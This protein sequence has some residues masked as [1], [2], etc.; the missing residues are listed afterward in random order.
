MRKERSRRIDHTHKRLAACRKGSRHWAH[1][2]TFIIVWRWSV[3]A[4]SIN[5]L[6]WVL[7]LHSAR[8]MMTSAAQQQNVIT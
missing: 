2:E 5:S 7:H 1:F 3:T 8:C 6:H 4:A